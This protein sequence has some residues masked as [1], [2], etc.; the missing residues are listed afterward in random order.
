MADLI[1]D[2]SYETGIELIDEQHKELFCKID[3]I[4]LAIYEGKG[5]T[6]VRELIKFLDD[7]ITKHF[8]IEEKML[9]DNLYPEISKHINNHK[10]F[11]NVFKEFTSDFIK[12]GPDNYLAI[13]MEKEIRFWWENHILKI[14]KLYVPYIKK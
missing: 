13:R 2:K 12:K 6:K 4:T 7:Y 9:F 1:W 14:D 8:E 10:E 3:E 11:I 5:K